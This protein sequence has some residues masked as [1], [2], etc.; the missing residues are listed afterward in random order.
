MGRGK[1]QGL[2]SSLCPS[3]GTPRAYF[4]PSPQPPNDT[5]G[6]LRKRGFG[7][8]LAEIRHLIPKKIRTCLPKQNQEGS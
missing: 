6:H 7:N 5:K 3:H 1:R 8:L 2:T 4:F